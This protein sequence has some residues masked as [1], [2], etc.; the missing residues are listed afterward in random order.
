[1]HSLM[2]NFIL[3]TMKKKPDFNRWCQQLMEMAYSFTKRN[4]R[5]ARVRTRIMEEI[6]G[7]LNYIVTAEIERRKNSNPIN[8]EITG[9]KKFSLLN[10]LRLF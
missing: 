7:K 9:Q 10:T 4:I 3:E 5:D 6:K 2:R 8:L 1:M